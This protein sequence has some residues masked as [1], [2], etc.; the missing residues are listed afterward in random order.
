MGLERVYGL[1]NKNSL[2][3]LPTMINGWRL[4]ITNTKKFKLLEKFNQPAF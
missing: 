4:A 1:R 2:F 3:T